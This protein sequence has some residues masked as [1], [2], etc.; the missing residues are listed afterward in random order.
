MGRTLKAFMLFTDIGFLVYWTITFMGWIPKEYLYQD[1]SNE[2]LVAWNM[3]F[4]PL[5]LFI[6]I[7]GLLSIYYYHKKKPVWSALCFTSLLLTF[8]SGLQAIAFWSVRLDFDM[9]WWTPN[10]FLLLYP[11]FFISKVM[12]G[13]RYSY[14]G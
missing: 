8:C 11:L 2:L 12:K 5:D 10:L 7:T 3:S 14:A 6:S 13:E 9:K 1:Y 4:I